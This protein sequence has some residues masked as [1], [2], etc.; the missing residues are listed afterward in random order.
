VPAD[1]ALTH[2]PS[3]PDAEE[4]TGEKCPAWLDY[5]QTCGDKCEPS[6]AE[7]APICEEWLSNEECYKSTEAVPEV[8]AGYQGAC[9][10]GTSCVPAPSAFCI[11]LEK[12][13]TDSCARS[14][15]RVC[16][17]VRACVRV[18]ARA[19]VRACVRACERVLASTLGAAMRV[20]ARL[21]GC[22]GTCKL[23]YEV[24]TRL[25]GCNT[26]GY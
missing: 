9:I 21:R 1:A 22:I 26:S 23:A 14:G 7:L 13:R 5:A 19:C 17:C 16:V 15:V 10:F 18:C 4:F 8:F 25:M 20:S 24:E 12:S 11:V 2:M 3:N 6:P